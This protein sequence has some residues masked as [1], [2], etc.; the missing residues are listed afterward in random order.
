MID[1]MKIYFKNND[2]KVN[3]SLESSEYQKDEINKIKVVLKDYDQINRTTKDKVSRI[4]DDCESSKQINIFSLI[5][6]TFHY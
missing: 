2:L 1:E 3:K 4:K 5:L 6:I